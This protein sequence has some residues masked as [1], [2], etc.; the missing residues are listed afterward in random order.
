MKV[1]HA[2]ETIKGGVATIIRQLTI[3]QINSGIESICLVPKTQA[4]ELAGVT[5]NNVK[6]YNSTGRNIPSLIKFMTALSVSLHRHRPDIVHL[7][8]T[9]AGLCGRIVLFFMFPF[10]RPKI[11][12]CPHGWAFIMDGG[13]TKKKVFSLIERLLI[14]I[15]DVVI[16][17][18]AFEKKSALSHGFSIEKIVVVNNC[19]E[20]PQPA[21][22]VN[23]SEPDIINLLYVGRFDHAKGFDILVKA[24]EQLEGQPFSLTAV[25]DTVQGGPAPK[26]LNNI[27]YA[28]WRPPSDLANYFSSADVLIMPS[29]WESFG[30]VAA[31]AHSYGLP[32]IASKCCSLPEVVEEGVT[33]YLFEPGSADELV[34]LLKK[35]PSSTWVEFGRNAHKRYEEKFKSEI[36]CAAVLRIY[37]NSPSPN[38]IGTSGT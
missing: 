36:M 16:C 18:S 19:V 7:H 34:T 9:F 27:N 26:R 23:H 30:L 6:T 28:G 8:S 4:V 5:P 3:S 12:Y 32:V 17:V 10:Y 35:T 20:P 38:T 31:E 15:T 11:I 33:G 37:T 21:K 24:M 25:G 14:R 29:R 22:A 2:A 1:L 13:K